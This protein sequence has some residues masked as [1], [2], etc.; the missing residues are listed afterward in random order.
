[1]NRLNTLSGKL[2]AIIFCSFLLEK[3]IY[4]NEN[5]EKAV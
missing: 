5:T 4:G 2:Y 3:S 1:M